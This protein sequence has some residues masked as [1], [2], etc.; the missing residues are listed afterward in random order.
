VLREIQPWEEGGKG[1]R[2]E[3]CSLEVERSLKKRVLVM[4][5]IFRGG[6]SSLLEHA[7]SPD[8]RIVSKGNGAVHN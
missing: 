5:F 4:E 8:R 3:E 1:G 7:K 2:G 6:L